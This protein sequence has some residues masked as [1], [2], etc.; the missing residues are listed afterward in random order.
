MCI[1]I[2]MSYDMYV[3]YH[4]MCGIAAST[5]D[6]YLIYV[7]ASCSIRLVVNNRGKITLTRDIHFSHKDL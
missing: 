4:I 7:D 1:C 5:I 3:S 2:P 6:M